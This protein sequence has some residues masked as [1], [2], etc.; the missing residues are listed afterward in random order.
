MLAL[1]PK[2]EAKIVYTPAHVRISGGH[3]AGLDL[4]HDGITDFTI[5][6]WHGRNTSGGLSP[7]G[8]AQGN[9]AAGYRAPCGRGSYNYAFVAGVRVG[10]K[11]RFALPSYQANMAWYFQSSVY[12]PWAGTKE[13]YLG[14][15]FDI[16]GEPHYGWARLNVPQPITTVVK[17]EALLT[18]YAYET[19]PNKPIITGATKHRNNAEQSASTTLTPRSTTLGMLAFGAPGLTVWRREERA[20]APQAQ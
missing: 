5:S 10:P 20:E 9:Q 19:I 7:V 8:I 15:K 3:S 18:G 2:T 6:I 4:N 13:R 1:A 12:G 17:L 11:L 16:R 14:L